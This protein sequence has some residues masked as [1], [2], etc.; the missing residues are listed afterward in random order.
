MAEGSVSSEEATKPPAKETAASVLPKQTQPRG[1]LL[2]RRNLLLGLS[3][4]ALGIVAGEIIDPK[5][6]PALFPPPMPIPAPELPKP[7]P[8][9]E[10]TLTPQTD[11]PGFFP[12]IPYGA[13]HIKNIESKDQFQDIERV[14][15]PETLNPDYIKELVLAL[16][17]E[18]GTTKERVE[19]VIDNLYHVGGPTGGGT[20]VM[21][22]ESGI[23]LTAAHTM[24]ALPQHFEPLNR[25][26]ISLATNPRTEKAFL[27]GQFM[28]MP[29]SD[30]GLVY[31]PT[32]KPR[33][34][35]QN[36]Q[37]D[38]SIP[39]DGTKLWSYG[40]FTRQHNGVSAYTLGLVS[41]QVGEVQKGGEMA[42]DDL[43]QVRGM[44]PYGG[45]SGA[46]VVNREGKVV[47]TIS[48]GLPYGQD[49]NVP[50]TGAAVARAE[51]IKKL[52][53]KGNETIYTIPLT[54]RG[55]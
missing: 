12:D 45:L 6:R 26:F 33:K 52:V 9:P 47:G 38:R 53:D 48:G 15:N 2:S 18:K 25:F 54:S 49:Q 36:L 4:A 29:G 50:F 42:Y 16:E 20:G 30:I 1:R 34:V 11:A 31:A 37:I 44:I 23:F 7:K 13:G 10:S 8:I 19:A 46:P 14:P 43:L 40:I 27:I 24:G 41:G 55:K 17:E 32:G 3:G 35:V 5:I 21:I 39:Q 51:D 28:V 22:D